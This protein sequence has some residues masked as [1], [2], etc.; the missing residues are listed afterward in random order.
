MQSSE[1]HTYC[2]HRNYEGKQQADATYQMHL[3]NFCSLLVW[4]I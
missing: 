2:F 1:V 3:I 4:S